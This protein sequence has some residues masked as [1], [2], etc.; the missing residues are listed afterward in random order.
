MLALLS[1]PQICKFLVIVWQTRSK[2]CTRKRAARA[3]RLFFLIQPITSLMCC[4]V[5]GRAVRLFFFIQPII[6]LICGVVFARASRSTNHIV[7]LS[8]P[9]LFLKKSR[10]FN[11][12]TATSPLEVCDSA[13]STQMPSNFTYVSNNCRSSLIFVVFFRCR[14]V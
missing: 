11:F 1:E 7:A 4:V 12:S 5:S 9:L 6:S 13:T 3:T 2:N 14:W 10:P 8:L